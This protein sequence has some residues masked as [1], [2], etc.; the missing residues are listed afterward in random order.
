M[1]IGRKKELALLANALVSQEADLI[2]VTGRRRIGKTFMITEA[3]QQHFVFEMIGV[4][5]GSLKVQLENFSDQLSIFAQTPIS[6]PETWADAFKLL[7]NYL[8]NNLS[9][10]K[11]VIFFDELP[12]LASPKSNFLEAFGYFW[13]SWASR[14]HI[15][16]V[17]CGSA[18]SWMIQQVVNHTGGL[19]N[20]ITKHIHLEPFS[21]AETE[22]F[23][24]SR[25]VFFDRYQIVQLY[26]AIGGVPH[27]LKEISGEKSAM[28]NIDAICFSKNGLLY[29]EFS[30][31]YA[32]LFT[33]SDNHVAIVRCL[34][35]K[36]QGMTRQEI[37][38]KGKIAN[39]GGL[40]KTLEELTQSG[41]VSEHFPFDKKKKEKIY[42]LSDEYS[43]FYLQFME[44]NRQQGSNIWQ[45]LSQTAAY[46]IWSGY[47]FEG[48]CLKHGERI[49]DALSI[50]GIY[51]TMTTF[52]RKGDS[53]EKGFQIDLLLDRNDHAINLFEVKFYNKPFVFSKEY[54]ESMQQKAWFFQQFS[55]TN[56]QVNWVFISTFGVAPNPHSISLLHRSLTL[57]DLF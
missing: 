18:A 40:T 50:T 52:Y 7:R 37:I 20:R 23:L 16:I 30:R 21:L 33:H 5:D 6:T 48:I 13:N 1:I 8:Q 29:N 36:R 45:H 19:H 42:R 43:L 9:T 49:K 53:N 3:L 27:Y 57:D 44:Q 14:Q 4:Q 2:A 56:K 22:A 32:S 10:H 31:L 34:A 46:K 47:A 39:G 12:W 15:M 25:T 51:S 55:K 26:M 35:Q 54:A 28:Q 41:F 24:K 11:K 17:I 38:E